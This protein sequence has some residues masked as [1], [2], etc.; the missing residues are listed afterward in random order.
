M[1]ERKV[2]TI[3]QTLQIYNTIPTD[4][5]TTDKEFN[6]KFSATNFAFMDEKCREKNSNYP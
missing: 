2:A 4:K 6:F 1:T 5:I 3:R